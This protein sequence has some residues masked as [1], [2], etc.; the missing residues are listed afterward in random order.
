MSVGVAAVMRSAQ[1]LVSLGFAAQ[2]EIRL[3]R[4][5]SEEHSLERVKSSFNGQQ[6]FL[7][8]SGTLIEQSNKDEMSR[9]SHLLGQHENRISQS[10]VEI[11]E[12]G[13]TGTPVRWTTAFDCS[14]TAES[15]AYEVFSE[16][17]MIP[18]T[19]IA[20]IDP[21]NASVAGREKNPAVTLNTRC[22]KTHFQMICAGA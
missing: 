18:L 3:R 17:E 14:A 15:F 10:R 19:L 11:S 13:Q 21:K 5:S 9:D 8:S 16:T 12:S 20:R 4:T 22:R 7:P 1:T 2:Q 6:R